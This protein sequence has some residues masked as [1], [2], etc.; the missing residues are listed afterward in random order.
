MVRILLVVTPKFPSLAPESKYGPFRLAGELDLGRY[1][2]L[3]WWSKDIEEARRLVGER[4]PIFLAM[5]EVEVR[6]YRRYRR[7]PPWASHALRV[8]YESP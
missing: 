2:L 4:F 5:V 3:L 8:G 1:S 7:S 6:G